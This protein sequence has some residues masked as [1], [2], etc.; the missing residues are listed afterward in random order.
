MHAYFNA[1]LFLTFIFASR[2]FFSDMGGALVGDGGFPLGDLLVFFMLSPA[3]EGA[4]GPSSASICLSFFPL[5]MSPSRFM[6]MAGRGGI[7]PPA[8]GTAVIVVDGAA[9]GLVGVTLMEGAVACCFCGGLAAG[10]F[11]SSSSFSTSFKFLPLPISLNKFIGIGGLA[12]AAAVACTRAAKGAGE[13][14][15]T[16]GVVVVEG[17]RGGA[18]VASTCC[19]GAKGAAVKGLRGCAGALVEGLRCG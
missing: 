11:F 19:R 10:V 5:L 2:A 14:A 18:A 3:P 4:T 1:P 12:T 8:P 7:G 9:E 13:G 17:R 15:A 6:D 16:A